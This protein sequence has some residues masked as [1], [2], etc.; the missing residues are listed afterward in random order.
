MAVGAGSIKRASKLNAEAE[1]KKAVAANAE[2]QAVGESKLVQAAEEVKAPAKKTTARKTATKK[3]TETKD[4]EVKTAVKKTTT[5]KTT[6]KKAV[7]KP[8]E[9]KIA[10]EKPV[11]EASV[12]TNIDPVVLNVVL[13][14]KEKKNQACHLTEDMPIYLL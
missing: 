12:I 8:V 14:K 13:G 2:E 1:T 7:E 6:A 11:V 4:A 3:T 5:R 9:E 10:E